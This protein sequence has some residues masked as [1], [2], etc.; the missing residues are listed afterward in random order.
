VITLHDVYEEGS[1]AVKEAVAAFGIRHPVNPD[2]PDSEANWRV[3]EL[4]FTRIIETIMRSAAPHPVYGST[5][6]GPVHRAE[7]AAVGFLLAVNTTEPDYRCPICVKRR[8]PLGA[9]HRPTLETR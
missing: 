7:N 3:A 4:H 8:Q 5:D 1:D 6:D 2:D 9:S